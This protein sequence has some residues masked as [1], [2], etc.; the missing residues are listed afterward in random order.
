MMTWCLPARLVAAVGSMTMACALGCSAQRSAPEKTGAAE[1]GAEACEAKRA[2]AGQTIGAVIAAHQSCA[3]DSDCEP[4]AQGGCIDACTRVMSATGTSAF[5]TAAA[6]VE[7]KYCAPF[8]AD[9]CPR[10]PSPPC[11]PLP[12]PACRTGVCR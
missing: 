12:P 4:V 1:P 2:A 10:P 6:E 8:R 9:R 3:K 5:A 11:A 7:A